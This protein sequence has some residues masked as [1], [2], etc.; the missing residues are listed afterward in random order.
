MTLDNDHL[1]VSEIRHI[2]KVNAWRKWIVS[3][4]SLCLA[5]DNYS[6]IFARLKLWLF[7]NFTKAVLL[8]LSIGGRSRF[9][10]L[11]GK[12]R[13]TS[14]QSVSSSKLYQHILFLHRTQNP[15][16]DISHGLCE[17]SCPKFQE[18]LGCEMVVHSSYSWRW[19]EFWQSSNSL[20]LYPSFGAGV[21]VIVC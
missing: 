2:W 3:L 6:F 10:Q 8:A 16:W 9:S 14:S 19:K 21:A 11:W 7:P 17:V 5:H 12:V 15:A 18:S 13:N 20:S 1:S 4:C